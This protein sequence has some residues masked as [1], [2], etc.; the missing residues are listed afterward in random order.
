MFQEQFWTIYVTIPSPLIENCELL[1]GV[2]DKPLDGGSPWGLDKAESGRLVPYHSA[3]CK[4][5]QLQI[6]LSIH[7]SI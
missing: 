7:V 5:E 6:T 4:N 1:S 3:F 2:D